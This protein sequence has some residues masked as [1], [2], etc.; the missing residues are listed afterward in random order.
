MEVAKFF[1]VWIGDMAKKKSQNS[2]SDIDFQN[3]FEEPLETMVD[4]EEENEGE[5][6]EKEKD[7]FLEDESDLAMIRNLENED[8]RIALSAL[9]FDEE[10]GFN[11]DYD[12]TTVSEAEHSRYVS[13]MSDTRENIEGVSWKRFAPLQRWMVARACS[14][15]GLHDM[16]R[17][18]ALGLIKARK[19]APELCLEDIYLD[20]VRDY[21]ETEEYDLAVG[22]VDKFEQTFPDEAEAALRVRALIFFAQD[23][24]DEG[25]K[26]V[27]KLIRLPFNRNIPGFEHDRASADSET[28]ES[29]IQY[30]IGYALYSLKKYDLAKHYF[31]HARDLATMNNDYEL[32]MAIDNAN[33]D[34]RHALEPSE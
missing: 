3:E 26:L 17:E 7:E 34:M 4:D 6:E 11:P 21:V 20:L 24:I 30:E 1:F 5:D 15:N 16:F 13:L 22:I 8:R 32:T 28:R 33:A 29:L 2:D 14:K 31:E 23:K 25:K 18:I 12:W 27:D 19:R 9:P 10:L